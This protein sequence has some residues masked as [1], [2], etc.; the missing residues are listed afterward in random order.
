MLKL[1][2]LQH[3]KSAISENGLITDTSQINDNILNW[4]ASGNAF[5]EKVA[6]HKLASFY[7]HNEDGIYDPTSGDYPILTTQTSNCDEQ[8]FI[9]SEMAYWVFLIQLLHHRFPNGYY[10]YH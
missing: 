1:Q 5:N 8:S 9:P 4:P 6:N 7:D 3:T 2:K 10:L